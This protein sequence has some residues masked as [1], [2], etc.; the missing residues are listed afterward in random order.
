MTH[1]SPIASTVNLLAAVQSAWS[2]I[3]LIA[4]DEAFSITLVAASS[5]VLRASAPAFANDTTVTLAGVPCTVNAVSDDGAWVLL[6]TPPPSSVCGLV[7]TECYAALSVTN[8]QPG[9]ASLAAHNATL[10][11]P[12]VCPGVIGT[13]GVVPFVAHDGATMLATQPPSGSGGFPVP[14]AAPPASSTEGVYFAVSCDK[15]RVIAC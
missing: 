12:P 15:V 5:I 7:N 10:T 11:C 1:G 9:T 3:V 13:D 6:E 4:R 2:T 14:V 8:L